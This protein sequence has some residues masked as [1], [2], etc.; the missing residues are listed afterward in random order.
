VPEE[1]TSI[2]NRLLETIRSLSID[3]E[4]TDIQVTAS[5]GVS[6]CRPEDN[7]E[8]LLKRA[9]HALYQAKQDGRDRVVIAP[10]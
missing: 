10:D 6:A 9:D 4:G 3:Y 1:Q 5:I 7:A 2:A 8:M